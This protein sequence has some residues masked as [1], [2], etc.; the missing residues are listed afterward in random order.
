MS[1]DRILHKTKTVLL[2]FAEYGWIVILALCTFAAWRKTAG[3]MMKG[4]WG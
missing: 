3:I 4:G 1:H 2:W